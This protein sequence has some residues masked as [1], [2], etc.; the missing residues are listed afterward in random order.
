MFRFI[1]LRIV[2]EVL[3]L[4]V[5]DIEINRVQRGSIILFIDVSMMSS[6]IV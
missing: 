1:V 6:I 5:S 3:T 4:L 2:A